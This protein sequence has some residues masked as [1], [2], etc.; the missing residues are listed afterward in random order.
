[1]CGIGLGMFLAFV[2]AV[3][4][5]IGVILILQQRRSSTRSPPPI[6]RCIRPASGS[7]Q[8]QGWRWTMPT[9]S[10]LAPRAGRMAA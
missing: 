1:M 4:I 7:R 3:I 2:I 5:I 6:G 9:A 8:R 10:S